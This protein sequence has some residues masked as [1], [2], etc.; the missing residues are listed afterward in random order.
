ML[1]LGGS[2]NLTS[3]ADAKVVDKTVTGILSRFLCTETSYD[4]AAKGVGHRHRLAI[5]GVGGKR[6]RLVGRSVFA[7]VDVDTRFSAL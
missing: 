4:R 5:Y 7:V 6:D 2:F 3:A 1:P